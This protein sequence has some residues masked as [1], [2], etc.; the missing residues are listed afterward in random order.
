LGG[1]S[2]RVFGSSLRQDN[3]GEAVRVADLLHRQIKA[4]K[5]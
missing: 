4:G 5:L 2:V 3:Q 1:D